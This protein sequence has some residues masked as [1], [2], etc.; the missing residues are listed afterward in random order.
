MMNIKKGVEKCMM[1]DTSQNAFW[2]DYKR[3]KQP[4]ALSQHLKQLVLDWW[5]IETTI[6]PNCKD[7]TRLKIGVKQFKVHPVHYL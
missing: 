5:R 7:I 2:M 6:S 3:A 4:N 1:L